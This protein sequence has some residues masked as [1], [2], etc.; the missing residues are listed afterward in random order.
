MLLQVLYWLSFKKILFLWTKYSWEYIT[1]NFHF[2][3]QSS[4]ERQTQK[5]FVSSFIGT[6]S[7]IELRKKFLFFRKLCF[8]RYQLFVLSK[9]SV[10]RFFVKNQL[11]EV[12]NQFSFFELFSLFQAEGFLKFISCS[13]FCFWLYFNFCFHNFWKRKQIKRYFIIFCLFFLMQDISPPSHGQ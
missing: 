9:S 10:W 1:N 3:I 5:L 12:R 13:M 8:C 4:Q 2:L 6:K 7:V 11:F